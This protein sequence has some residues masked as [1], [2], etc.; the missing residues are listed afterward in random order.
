MKMINVDELLRELN[1]IYSDYLENPCMGAEEKEQL[2][3]GIECA[4]DCVKEM[5]TIDIGEF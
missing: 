5:P 2:L 3:R 1:D 4:I